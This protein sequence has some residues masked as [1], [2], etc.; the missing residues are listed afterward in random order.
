[1]P[2]WFLFLISLISG[3]G[4]WL[5][6]YLIIPLLEEAEITGTDIHK[7]DQPQLAEMGGL[8]LVVGVAGGLVLAVGAYAFLHV[9]L[10][11]ISL[12]AV[13]ATVLIVSFIGV[14][15]D[16]LEIGQLVKAASPLLAALPLMAIRAGARTL[17]IPFV[18]PVYFGLSYPLLLVPFGI[19]GAANATNMLAGFNGLESGVSLVVVASLGAVAFFTK[20]WTAF[21]VLLAAFSSLVALLYYNWH[22]A[23][24]LVGDVGTLTIGALMASAVIIGN[25][26]TAGAVVIIP[27]FLDFLLKAVSG[28][29][30]RGW[31]GEYCQEDDRLYCP[32][33]RPVSLPQLIMKVAGGIK[34]RNLVL[35]VMALEAATGLGA[36]LLYVLK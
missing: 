10:D 1:M 35:V 33:G 9:P 25:F 28:F 15:D 14:F 4:T 16:L 18:G 7:P 19:T 36:V 34:E 5:T 26:E 2:V 27:H 30:S 23:R 21:L 17:R 11:I 24:V 31:L 8:G 12:L 32:E 29:P 22:P 13:L 3:I 6:L 20:S